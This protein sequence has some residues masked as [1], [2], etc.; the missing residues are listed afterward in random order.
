MSARSLQMLGE[1]LGVAA[2]TGDTGYVGE[3]V[4]SRHRHAKDVRQGIREAGCHI[5]LRQFRVTVE[6]R[7]SAALCPLEVMHV[8]YQRGERDSWAFPAGFRVQFGQVDLPVVAVGEPEG[9]SWKVDH[10]AVRDD[11]LPVEG[12]PAVGGQDR[13]LFTLVGQGAAP[14]LTGKWLFQ[15]VRPAV[16]SAFQQRRL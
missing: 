7:H 8:G 9:W 13:Y 4:L 1:V 10:P 5:R 12:H 15:F 11:P 3:Y 2:V 6:G 14:L 16:P